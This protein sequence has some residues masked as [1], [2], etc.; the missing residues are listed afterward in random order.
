[1]LV[2]DKGYYRLSDL[3]KHGFLEFLES[4]KQSKVISG[5]IVRIQILNFLK[6]NI[7][8]YSVT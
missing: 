2:L 4:I 8:V 7:K 6:Q 1:M 5:L 3:K